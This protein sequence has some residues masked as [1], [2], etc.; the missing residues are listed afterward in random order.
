M[1]ENENSSVYKSRFD[2]DFESKSH[3][4]KA[5]TSNILETKYQET[6]ENSRHETRKRNLSCGIGLVKPP[7]IINKKKQD[8]DQD[9]KTLYIDAKQTSLIYVSEMLKHFIRK[10]IL[11]IYK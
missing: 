7:N 6:T 4:I 1:H 9:Y 5:T 2:R 10:S 11:L 3:F 8:Q